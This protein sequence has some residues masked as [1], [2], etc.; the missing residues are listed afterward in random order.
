M[1]QSRAI[2][3]LHRRTG[4]DTEGGKSAREVDSTGAGRAEVPAPQAGGDSPRVPP[5]PCQQTSQLWEALAGGRPAN[6]AGRR[7]RLFVFK[8]GECVQA[9]GVQEATEG[10]GPRRKG[11][12]RGPSSGRSGVSGLHSRRP[13]PAR[14]GGSEETLAARKRWL[15]APRAAALQARPGARVRGHRGRHAP[16]SKAWAAV[17]AGACE[18]AWAARSPL[19]RGPHPAPAAACAAQ[20]HRVCA[21]TQL[22]RG[23]RPPGRGPGRKTLQASQPAAAAAA[24][25]EHDC[26]SSARAKRGVLRDRLA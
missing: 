7:R 4:G 13:R 18:R 12:S 11:D 26:S 8:I 6:T 1:S 21:A 23:P 15:L 24:A 17:G 20:P 14:G 25:Q 19:P 2:L 22:A 10:C 3:T 16:T 9:A 5:G